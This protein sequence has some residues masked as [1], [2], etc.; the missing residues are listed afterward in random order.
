MTNNAEIPG[1]D[2]DIR[3]N[4]ISVYSQ[5]SNEDFPVL[6]AF[7]QYIDAEHEKARKRIIAMGFFFMLIVL[8]LI[9]AF[10]T[11]L[12]NVSNRNQQLNDRLV[13]LAM[14]DRSQ[15][16]A[17][18]VVVQPPQENAA[19][20]ALT[21]KLEN[22]QKQLAD[23]QKQMSENQIRAERAAAEAATKLAEA[24]AAEAIARNAEAAAKA[25]LSKAAGQPKGPTKEEQEIAK[26]KALLTAERE[27]VAA[28]KEKTKQAELEIY[29][30]KTYP[31]HYD[32]NKK[33]EK[34]LLVKPPAPNRPSAQ[35]P[36]S[37]KVD[38]EELDDDQAIS[39]FD[40]DDEITAAKDDAY[41][42]PV[43][44]KSAASQRHVRSTS[45][46]EWD[47]PD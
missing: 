42:I 33:K 6:K 39:Y 17:T 4:A 38:D 45:G 37:A 24:K 2:G 13:E 41:V 43:E 16:A 46:I 23:N 10:V 44:K 35:P 12:V 9:A 11:M 28:E 8:A 29:R 7:Q 34:S 21:T 5:D 30:R 3:A 27:K 19:L 40:D 15:A 14:K 47:I 22:M 25:A 32:T 36:S 20:L 18:P 26:L 1:V 31:E